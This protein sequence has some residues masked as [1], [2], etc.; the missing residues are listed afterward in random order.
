MTLSRTLFLCFFVAGSSLAPAARDATFIDVFL[1]HAT[2]PAKGPEVTVPY[3][4]SELRFFVDPRSLRVRYK[5]EGL[6]HNWQKRPDE[7]N[8]MVRFVNKNGDQ[9]LQKYFPTIGQSEGWNGSVEH[10]EFT[11]RTGAVTV[12]PDAEYVSIAMSSSGPASAVGILAIS[13]ITVTSVPAAGETPKV[14]LDDSRIPGSL[15]PNWVKSGTHPSMASMI[16][17]TDDVRG[18]PIFVIVDDDIKAHADWATELYALPKVTPGEILEVRWKEAYSIG[19]GGSFS[20]NYERLPPGSYRFVV[21]ELA[22]TGVPLRQTSSVIIDVQRPYWK[23]FWFWAACAVAAPI[24][25]I[26]YGRHLIRRRINRHLRHAQLIADERLRIA[27]DLHDDLGTRL[28]HISLLGA[29]AGSTIPDQD[30]R[31]TF[32]QITNMAGELISALSETVWM[33]NSN[34]NQLESLVNFLCRLV[35]ELCRLSEIRCRI[36]ALSVTE[37]LSISHE[38]RHNFSLSVK[39]SVNNALRHSFA[40]EIKMDIKLEGNLLKISVT[41]NGIGFSRDANKDGSGLKS[42]AER[43]TLIRGK[44]L[45]EALEEGGLRVS[46]EA[47]VS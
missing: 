26:L 22:N 39:E 21:E 37:N 43:M 24:L 4:T 29:H 31:A 33:L 18:S 45:I 41:D 1:D 27:R 2:D 25:P 11:S 15:V 10:S 12:P 40:T 8:F 19:A 7:M 5:L 47:P 30:A 14:F 32:Q 38:F 35:S 6:D 16:H 13:G 20:V 44:C 28:S 36:D 46:L 23:N 34:N 3:D 42:I 17:P 9:I